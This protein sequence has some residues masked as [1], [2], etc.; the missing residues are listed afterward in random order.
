[1]RSNT[2]VSNLNLPLGI[3]RTEADLDHIGHAAATDVEPGTTSPL[4]AAPLPSAGSTRNLDAVQR[5]RSSSRV[6]SEAQPEV[7]IATPDASAVAGVV[8]DHA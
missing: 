3:E 6:A 5:A 4:V 7:L 8:A 1:M 2:R